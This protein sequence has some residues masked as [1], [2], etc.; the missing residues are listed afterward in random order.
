MHPK[1]RLPKKVRVKNHDECEC[2]KQEYR[3]KSLVTMMY[4][5]GESSHVYN[6]CIN[7]AQ[8]HFACPKDSALAMSHSLSECLKKCDKDITTEPIIPIDD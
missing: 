7:C 2:C 6:F 3:S 5:C 1:N 4:E 8:Y